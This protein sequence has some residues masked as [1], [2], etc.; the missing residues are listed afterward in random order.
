MEKTDQPDPNTGE[1]ESTIDRRKPRRAAILDSTERFSIQSEYQPKGDQPKAIAE[2]VSNIQAGTKRQVLLGVTGSGKTFTM[3]H[4]IQSLNRPALVLAHNKTL[5]AQLYSE[6]AELFP[7]NAVRYFVSYYDYYQPEAYVPS[8]NTYIEKDAS[9]NDEIDKLRH[10]ATKALLERR[11]V[12]V[13]ASVSCIYGL[14]DPENYFDLMLYLEQGERF[15]RHQALKRLVELQYVRADEEFLTGTFRVR[16]DVVE[17]CPASE[18]ERSI[19][20]EFFGDEI[21]ALSEVDR[22]TGKVLR[23]LDKV[24]VYPASHFV[25]RKAELKRAAKTI[26]IELDERL[27]ELIRQGKT[28]EA[29]RLEQ[30]TLYD[31][32]LI[33]EMGFC[34][35]IENYSRHLTGRAPGEP[36]PTLLDYF[37]DDFLVFIDE[38]HVTVPQLVGMYRGDRAR[39]QTLVDYGFRLPSA[40]DNRPLMFQEFE[41]RAKVVT[42]VSATPSQFELVDSGEHVVEQIIRPTGL[43]DPQV[44]IRPALSQVDDFLAEVHRVAGRGE[45]ALVTTLTKKMAEDLTEYYREV[46]VRVRY[47]HSDVHTLDRI[48]L[49][50]ALRR[51]DFDLLVGINLLR[52]GLDLPEVSLVAIMDADKE[53]FLRSTTSLVQTIGRASRHLNGLVLL[54]ADR[55]TDSI[56]SAMRETDRRRELQTKYNTDHGITPTSVKR[57]PEA[58]MVSEDELD[59]L[60]DELHRSQASMAELPRDIASCRKLILETRGE[61]TALA[62][63]REFE[64]AAI[65]RDRLFVL[66][67]YLLSL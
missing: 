34:P 33:E 14:G 3:A 57:A 35:G 2:L 46:G 66:E 47:L 44:E 42:Y 41:A 62:K 36:P 25:T 63:A 49:I 18:S 7:T 30:R 58:L 23:K 19:R 60:S 50:R 8:T 61:M 64:K 17:V 26:R 39:K 37:P 43:I 16:G 5:A 45:R 59:A 11:D 4:V 38:S 1:S 54:Y 28:L 15:D 29:A 27:A 12:I 56:K 9:V 13:V 20:I 53:G 6:F 31:L 24:C 52:E 10:A 40:I 22:L 67:K 48:D 65:L 55:S 51:G 21:E 32:E